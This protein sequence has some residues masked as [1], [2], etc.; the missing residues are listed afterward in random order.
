MKQRSMKNVLLLIML[1]IAMLVCACGNNGPRVEYGNGSNILKPK[2]EG[3]DEEYTEED[4]PTLY[5]FE[6]VNKSAN[7][8]SFMKIGGSNREF[9]YSYSGQTAFVTRYGSY[10]T[11]DGLNPGDVVELKIKESEQ[12]CLEVKVSDH[13]WL[14]DDIDKYDINMSK[15][16]LTVGS[17]KY[18]ITENVPV[19]K[20]NEALTVNDLT[21]NESIALYGYDKTIISVVITTGHGT[22]A[23]T[24]TDDYEGG[25][26]VL[27]NVAAAEITKDLRMNVKC[28]TYLLMVSANGMSG[29]MQVTIE[30]GKT[31]FINLSSFVKKTEKRGEVTFMVSVNGAKLTINGKKIDYSNPISLKY[32]VYK[33]VC[34]ADGYDEWVRY[35][36]VNSKTAYIDI[37]LDKTVI[38]ND[39]DDESD[40]DDDD[41]DS[42]TVSGDE[43][44]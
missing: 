32:G 13:V 23:F 34:T 6:N 14:F 33:V 21:G 44:N 15:N 22:L 25:Y 24:H 2:G 8:L 42:G 26:F 20:G 38:S 12:L 11:V 19:Y 7:L 41:D 10:M 3:D 16:M 37:N 36:I 5:I 18:Y 27:G 31:A 30:D 4:L 17:N 35:I 28:G 9:I 39:D 40:D 29:S 43:G 1:T